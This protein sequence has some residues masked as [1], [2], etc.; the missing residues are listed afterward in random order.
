M[1]I[2]PLSKNN[3]FNTNFRGIETGNVRYRHE[4][5]SKDISD[6]EK[7]SRK[8]QLE[9]ATDIYD[10][11]ML[12]DETEEEFLQK[13]TQDHPSYRTI[14]YNPELEFQFT[15][16]SLPKVLGK[17]DISKQDWENYNEDIESMSEKQ[18][19]KVEEEL[20]KNDLVHL[21]KL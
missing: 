16:Y 9:Y 3:A 10:C 1:R 2:L 21:I 13:F 11:Y 15:H 8:E 19:V 12:K 6:T 7:G 17:I 14:D 20:L 18:I 5:I 4:T